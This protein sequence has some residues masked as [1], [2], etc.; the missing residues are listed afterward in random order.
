MA[1]YSALVLFSLSL[2]QSF[3]LGTYATTLTI[4][5]N[6]N[7]IIWPA[8]LPNPGSPLISPS[9]FS[10]NAGDS[11]TLPVPSG[12][13]GRVWARTRCAT[14]SVGKFSCATG[15]CGSSA[16]DCGGGGGEISSTS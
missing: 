10:L 7:D 16:V 3:F 15:D 6:C 9:G 2:L 11:E 4:T 1:A 5:N 12:W 8:V 14:T 13:S